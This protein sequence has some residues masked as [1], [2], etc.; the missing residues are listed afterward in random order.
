MLV[1]IIFTSALIASL[2]HLDLAI[3]SNTS[4]LLFSLAVRKWPHIHDFLQHVPT[5][6]LILAAFTVLVYRFTTGIQSSEKPQNDGPKVLFLPSETAHIRFFPQ[7]HAFNYSYLLAGVPVGFKGSLGGIISVDEES[8]GLDNRKKAKTWF[9]VDAEDYLAR[10][11][12]HLGLKVKL[13][14]FL[15]SEVCLIG[16]FVY[17]CLTVT[18][19]KIQK[20]I[21]THTCSL[22]PSFWAISTI[23]FLSGIFITMSES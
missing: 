12:G 6:W 9:S 4:L 11:H 5:T 2:N 15:L 10:G 13:D 18:R 23:R 8:V 22:P 7:R 16:A 19:A 17:R 21:L 1:S 14:R 3:T 20:N